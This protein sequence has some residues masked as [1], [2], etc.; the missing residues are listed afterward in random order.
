MPDIGAIIVIFA[1]PA[2]IIWV[3]LRQ[4]SKRQTRK[5]GHWVETAQGLR[6]VPDK[7]PQP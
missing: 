2:A 6:W 4:A 1:L 7:P 5:E 3:A